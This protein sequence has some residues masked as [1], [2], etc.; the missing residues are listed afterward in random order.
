VATN[1]HLDQREVYCRISNRALKDISKPEEPHWSKRSKHEQE[2]K[3]ELPEQEE[4]YQRSIACNTCP[5]KNL[6]EL[7]EEPYIYAKTELRRTEQTKE[8]AEEAERKTE[9]SES[10]S[11]EQGA[12][13]HIY[14]YIYTCI[15][16]IR[17]L[18]CMHLTT[19]GSY[20]SE[21]H[22]NGIHYAYKCT[23]GGINPYI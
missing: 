5:R 3:T 10:I 1:I 21:I 15:Y 7:Q 12:D 14:I 2:E 23:I 17:E 8:Q 13:I 16:T 22:Y 9:P 20:R 11:E 4:P 19:I 18:I 6:E